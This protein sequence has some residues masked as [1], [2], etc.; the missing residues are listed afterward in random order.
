MSLR[1]F[2]LESEFKR[3]SLKEREFK[4]ES[5]RAR[6]RIKSKRKRETQSVRLTVLF[7]TIDAKEMVV[8][9]ENS[10]PVFHLCLLVYSRTIHARSVITRKHLDEWFEK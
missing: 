8:S 1:E 5:E 3:E 2:E 9:P 4:R 10:V 6:E 7:G